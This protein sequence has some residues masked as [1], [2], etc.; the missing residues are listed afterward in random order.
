[1]VDKISTRV[2]ELL[3]EFNI[4]KPPVS[5]RQIVKKYGLLLT[6]LPADNDISGAIIR[7]NGRV[8]IAV[9]TSQPPNRQ[10]FTVAHELAHYFLH[11]ELEE[12]VDEDFWVAW[13]NSESSKAINWR[14]IEANSFA[15]QLLMPAEFLEKD[16][17]ALQRIDKRT[18]ALLAA[19]YGVSAEAMRFRLSNLGILGRF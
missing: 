12:H 6:S 16:L 1:M 4:R 10:R 13:R 3:R 11:Q 2:D 5:V 9:N 7:K 14:E 17:H 8:V 19:R 15:A 18:I